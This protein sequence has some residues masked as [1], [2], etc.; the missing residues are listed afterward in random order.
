MAD[1]AVCFDV[2]EALD[3]AGDFTLEV[4]FDGALFDSLG[5]R[6]F[7]IN[8]DL[9]G[10]RRRT[11]SCILENL[12]GSSR[13]DTIEGGETDVETLVVGDVDTEDTHE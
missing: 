13:A 11:Y 2:F 6:L 4:A 7:L 9:G 8:R 10:L 1:T 12:V 3:V 5:D